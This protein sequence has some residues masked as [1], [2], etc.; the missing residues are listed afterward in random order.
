MKIDVKTIRG[1]SRLNKT[2]NYDVIK[3]LDDIKPNI[4]FAQLIKESK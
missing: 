3:N 4:T 2:H 1:S